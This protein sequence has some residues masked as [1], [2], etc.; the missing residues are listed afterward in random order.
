[1]KPTFDDTT[2]RVDRPQTGDER[3]IVIDL[4]EDERSPLLEHIAVAQVAAAEQ[5]DPWDERV[6]RVRRSEPSRR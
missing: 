5:A 3:Q 2:D 6:F 1:M 4:T